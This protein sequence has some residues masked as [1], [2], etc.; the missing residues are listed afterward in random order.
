M[1]IH[2][3]LTHLYLFHTEYLNWHMVVMTMM[4]IVN[5]DNDCNHQI[6][7]S[8][9]FFGNEMTVSVLNHF[10]VECIETTAF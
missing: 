10:K 5:D 2:E 9:L 7:K 1:Y 4:L 8:I 6:S 3:F